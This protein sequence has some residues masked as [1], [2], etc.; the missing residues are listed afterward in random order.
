MSKARELFGRYFGGQK[1]GPGVAASYFTSFMI[2][3]EITAIVPIPVFYAC[4][5]WLDVEAPSI[6][7][8]DPRILEY[9]RKFANRTFHTNDHGQD[10]KHA[11]VSS[12]SDSTEEW[13]ELERKVV[14]L[15]YAY[16][17][18]KVLMPV[19]IAASVSLTPWFSR[20]ITSPLMRKTGL[21]KQQQ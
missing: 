7:Y 19:R 15:A 4:F 14:H 16:A 8:S 12:S 13:R 21:L 2:L 11:Q 5:Q 1:L 20:R 18:T 17:L 6:I 9:G 3:H 10:M